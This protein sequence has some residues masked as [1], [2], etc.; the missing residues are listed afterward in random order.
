MFL[1]SSIYVS[2]VIEKAQR[3]LCFFF[4]KRNFHAFSAVHFPAAATRFKPV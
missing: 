2:L 1:I 3:K 4:F